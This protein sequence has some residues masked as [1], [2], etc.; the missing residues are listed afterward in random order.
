MTTWLMKFTIEDWDT[1]AFLDS[2]TDENTPKELLT[3]IPEN[4]DQIIKEKGVDYV[5]SMIAQ[6][7]S[8]E[9]PIREAFMHGMRQMLHI[10][11][12]E[13]GQDF[14]K[15]YCVEAYENN[16]KHCKVQ[17]PYCKSI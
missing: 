5:F 3:N 17:C 14:S 13:G 2:I 8:G 4:W 11:N 15:F 7:K 6:E 10:L 16:A 12:L 9:G 1:D